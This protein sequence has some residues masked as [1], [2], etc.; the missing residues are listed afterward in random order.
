MPASAF[1]PS[2]WYPVDCMTQHC[3]ETMSRAVATECQ[4]H[5]DRF[6]CPDALLHY[7]PKFDE[8]GIIVHDGGTASAGISFCPWCGTRL[9]ESR[10]D[11]WFDELER[12]GFSN[13]SDQ[14]IP[15]QFHTD[16]WWRDQ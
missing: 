6:D 9:P 3:C 16:A 7:S 15:T 1:P 11:R 13:P 2:S 8:Y 10:R 4:Q 14:E 5:P 12:L